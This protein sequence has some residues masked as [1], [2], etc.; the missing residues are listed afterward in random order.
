MTDLRESGCLT[1]DTRILRADTGAETT[2]GEL[3]AL[4]DQGRPGLGARRA[5]ALRP[6]APDA[7]L[8]DRHEAGLPADAW[9]PARTIRATANHPFLTYDGWT[10]L[11]ELA[12]R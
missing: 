1:A 9:R 11:G 12:R 4:G 7:R 2:L 5:A 3:F 10:P 8:P 6:P